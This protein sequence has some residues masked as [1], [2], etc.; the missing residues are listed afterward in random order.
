MS[1]QIVW[2]DLN[3]NPSEGDNTLGFKVNTSES[4]PQNFLDSYSEFLLMNAINDLLDPEDPSW[5]IPFTN[6]ADTTSTYELTFDPSGV[7]FQEQWEFNITS[8]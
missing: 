1:V 5:N 4:F 7:S 8:V 6:P 3:L 2:T